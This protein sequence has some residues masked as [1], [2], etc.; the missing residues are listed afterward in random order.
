MN[1]NDRIKHVRTALKMNQTDF[2]KKLGVTQPSLSDIEKGKTEN[3]DS[4]NIKLICTEFNVNENWL[5]TGE[6]SMF[7][8]S[9]LELAEI[10]G[11]RINTLSEFQIEAIKIF[12]QLTPEEAE[13]IMKFVKKL[14]GKD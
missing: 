5:R 10:I 13:I 4:R 8:E 9:K 7:N 12:A 11:E 6:G 1:I 14:S 2:A 3:I